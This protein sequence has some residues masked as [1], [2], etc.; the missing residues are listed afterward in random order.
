MKNLLNTPVGRLRLIA[1]VEGISF[2][3]LLG[4]AM[5]LKYAAGI[6]EAVKVTGWAHGLLFI[7]FCFALLFA[8][9]AARWTLFFAGITFVSA[10]LP[11]GTFVMDSHLKKR[12]PENLGGDSKK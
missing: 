2:L 8:M 3:I 1:C 11:F 7:L 5:P 9:R 10:L 6:E 12:D 4:I